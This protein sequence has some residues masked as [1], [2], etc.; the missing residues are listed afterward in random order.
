MASRAQARDAHITKVGTDALFD[1]WGRITGEQVFEAM[2]EA[3]NK[4]WAAGWEQGHEEGELDGFRRA[5]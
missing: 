5:D 1:K 4:G 2:Q 3:F